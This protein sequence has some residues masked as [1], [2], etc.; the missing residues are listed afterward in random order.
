VGACGP[1]RWLNAESVQRGLDG[2][3]GD[4]LAIVVLA[5]DRVIAA[6]GD[7]RVQSLGQKSADN[8][9]RA[10][11]PEVF[12]QRQR[13]PVRPLAGGIQDHELSVRE[14]GHEVVTFPDGQRGF[15][16]ASTAPRM[17]PGRFARRVDALAEVELRAAR[18]DVDF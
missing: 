4:A 10:A 7:L 15:A 3:Q 14:L 11:A 18:D 17:H 13:E 6:R 5:P 1:V 8:L 9:L 16:G 12:G 2:D